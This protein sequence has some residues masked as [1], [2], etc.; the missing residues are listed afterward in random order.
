MLSDHRQIV[1]DAGRYQSSCDV[2]DD[3]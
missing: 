3:E 1:F 2:I